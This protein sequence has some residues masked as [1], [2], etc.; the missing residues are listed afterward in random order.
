[1]LYNKS[2]E[3]ISL[4]IINWI[5]NSLNNILEKKKLCILT[6]TSIL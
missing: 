2:G 6:Y 5:Y 1:M 3:S 4:S